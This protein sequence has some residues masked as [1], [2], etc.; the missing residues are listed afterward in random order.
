MNFENTFKLIDIFF[1]DNPN[2]IVKHHL[3]S[4]NKFFNEDLKTI[5]KDNNPKKYMTELDDETNLYKY[6]ADLY[7]GG[8]SGEKIY[9][10]KP[11][12]YDKES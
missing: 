11:L 3:D 9:Y 8:K 5:I 10:G 1:R 4:Y 12:I 7:I 6:T 2:I